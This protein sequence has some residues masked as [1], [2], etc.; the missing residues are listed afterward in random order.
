VGSV[1]NSI[2]CGGI[3]GYRTGQFRRA[4]SPIHSI[5]STRPG[6]LVSWLQLYDQF[7]IG[8]A[9]LDNDYMIVFALSNIL[10]S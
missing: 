7:Y 5:V 10:Y 1:L 8:I 4:G 3:V 2:C 9:R 6:D